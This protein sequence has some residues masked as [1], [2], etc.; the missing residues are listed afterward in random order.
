M[1]FRSGT[2]IYKHHFQRDQVIIERDEAAQERQG[3]EPKQAVICSG[4]KRHAKEIKFSKKSGERRQSG[5]RQKK[6]RHGAG[7]K[8]RALRHSGKILQIVAP[9]FAPNHLNNGESANQRDRVNARVKKCG[10][11]TVAPAGN[12]SEESIAAVSD[13]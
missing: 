12:N 3:D 5:E 6:D 2:L 13:R 7:K 11:K 1:R 8:R 9:G 10:R 4:T